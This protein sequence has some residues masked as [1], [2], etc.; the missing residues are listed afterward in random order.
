MLYSAVLV[1]DAIAR[2]SSLFRFGNKI[3]WILILLIVNPLLLDLESIL[4]SGI[5][6]H[7]IV[8][9]H[10]HAFQT[11]SGILIFAIS[12][13]IYLLYFIKNRFKNPYWKIKSKIKEEHT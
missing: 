12:P 10:Y 6:W 3:F 7:F 9:L 11:I 1:V 4:I 5:F 13:S 8:W 2:P